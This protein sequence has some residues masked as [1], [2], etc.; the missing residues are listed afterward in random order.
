[1]CC[2]ARYS[3]DL[4]LSLAVWMTSLRK[5]ECFA[6]PNTALDRSLQPRLWLTK[7]CWKIGGN[8]C[9]LGTETSIH[10]MR[11]SFKILQ[12][13]FIKYLMSIRSHPQQSLYQGIFLRIGKLSTNGF[14]QQMVVEA[15]LLNKVTSYLIRSLAATNDSF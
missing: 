5:F 12:N 2:L 4:Q 15:H 6:I 3:A 1:M 14:K 11:K 10:A 9:T 8:F 7:L 13:T